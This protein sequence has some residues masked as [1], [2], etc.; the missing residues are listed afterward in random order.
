MGIILSI[1]QPVRD[2]VTLEWEKEYQPAPCLTHKNHS[3]PIG[4]YCVFRILS[5]YSS[6]SLGKCI[7]RGCRA[8]EMLGAPSDFGQRKS[9]ASSVLRWMPGYSPNSLAPLPKGR[10]LTACKWAQCHLTRW[11][12][13]QAARGTCKCP[14]V[15]VKQTI[16]SQGALKQLSI[17][18]L[19]T[20]LTGDTQSLMLFFWVKPYNSMHWVNIIKRLYLLTRN[21]Q[22]NERN[23]QL[24]V[25]CNNSYNAVM[26]KGWWSKTEHL[27]LSS[28][29]S[30]GFVEELLFCIES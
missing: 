29:L 13:E 16:P 8:P 26:D 2:A 6:A 22:S 25:Q 7:R 20:L 17:P 10:G 4:V 14:A 27:N 1:W 18:V 19:Q 15:F 21:L 24:Q 30:E 28:G 12:W 23:K 9:Q 11:E 3:V 5:K